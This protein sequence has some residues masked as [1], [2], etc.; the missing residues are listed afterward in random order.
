MLHFNLVPYW[1]FPIFQPL[2]VAKDRA[3]EIIQCSTTDYKQELQYEGMMLLKELYSF[4][5][6][7][8]SAPRIH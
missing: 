3:T 5:R 7:T 8:V 1:T 4:V 2:L 6:S